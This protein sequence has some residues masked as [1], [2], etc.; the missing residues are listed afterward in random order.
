MDGGPGP[1]LDR[2][3][4][5]RIHEGKTRQISGQRHPSTSE[6]G[7][8]AHET[9]GS[10]RNGTRNGTWRNETHGTW[11]DATYG[12]DGPYGSDASRDA[13]WYDAR[14]SYDGRYVTSL[15]LDKNALQF[16]FYRTSAA[17]D[18]RTSSPWDD[19]SSRH[20]T[21]HVQTSDVERSKLFLCFIVKIEKKLQK[22]CFSFHVEKLFCLKGLFLISEWRDC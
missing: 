19:W 3:H 11:R 16:V 17:H 10:R 18:G 8:T 5:C 13:A 21:S 7:R 9:N 14:P 20:E 1:V 15:V 12:T 6:P 2:R 22:T 4:H